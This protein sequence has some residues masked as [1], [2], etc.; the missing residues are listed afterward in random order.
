L[1]LAAVVPRLFENGILLDIVM[2]SD[3]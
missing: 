3:G 1:A 2:C